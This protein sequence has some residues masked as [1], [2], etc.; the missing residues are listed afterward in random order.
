MRGE[1]PPPRRPPG[2]KA[3]AAARVPVSVLVPELRRASYPALPLEAARSLSGV[4]T[5]PES[6]GAQR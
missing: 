5:L 1:A 6:R 4:R 3:A 2:E